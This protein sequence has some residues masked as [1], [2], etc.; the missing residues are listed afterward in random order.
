[1]AIIALS[2]TPVFSV[3]DKIAD[4]RNRGRQ[5]GTMKQDLGKAGRAADT[6]GLTCC[7]PTILNWY[8]WVS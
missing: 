1:M 2:L 7:A 3:L 5:L 6:P 4:G 8:V